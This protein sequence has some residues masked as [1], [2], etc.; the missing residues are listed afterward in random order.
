[1]ALAGAVEED[2]NVK[3][4]AKKSE[5]KEKSLCLLGVSWFLKI[6]AAHQKIIFIQTIRTII[7][8]KEKCILIVLIFTLCS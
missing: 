5:R 6:Q 2:Q 7:I 4:G 3:S 1:M 8:K